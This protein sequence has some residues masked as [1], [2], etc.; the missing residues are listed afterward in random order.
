MIF[1]RQ[2]SSDPLTRTDF[3]SHLV[4]GIDDGAKDMAHALELIGKLS[5]LGYKKL[6]TTPHIKHGQYNN[7][8]D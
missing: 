4:P 8:I 7:T 1:S 3:H 2:K 6:I 5:S